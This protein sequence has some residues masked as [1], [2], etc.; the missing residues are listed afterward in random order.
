MKNPNDIK[1]AARLFFYTGVA[2]LG[3]SLVYYIFFPESFFD[4]SVGTYFSISSGPLWLIF[5]VYLLLL[6]ALYYVAARGRLK[7]RK[8]MLVSHY[9]FVVMFLLV[10]LLFSQFNEDYTRRL[11]STYSAMGVVIIYST[12]FLVDIILFIAG[13][14][15]LAANLLVLSDPSAKRG[16]K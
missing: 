14:A 3:I 4:L 11:L 2:T 7:V 15:I 5:T 16:K 10:F 6:S 1:K 12:I 13:I 8:W 9:L